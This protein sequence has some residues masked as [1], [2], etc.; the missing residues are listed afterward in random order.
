MMHCRATAATWWSFRGC[1]RRPFV[2]SQ[3]FERHITKTCLDEA[4]AKC[5]SSRNLMMR[6]MTS[7]STLKIDSASTLIGPKSRTSTATR[8]PSHARCG[9]GVLFFAS[10]KAGHHSNWQSP[11]LETRVDLDNSHA[12]S[13]VQVH[14]V[15]A[16]SR[17]RGIG[18]YF[19]KLWRNLVNSPTMA[20]TIQLPSDDR[21]SPGSSF[22]INGLIAN[23]NA[24]L[25]GPEPNFLPY[26]VA[27]GGRN[28]VCN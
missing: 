15:A 10:K 27:Q 9:L 7:P 22:A 4:I 28:G 17:P 12:C 5:S 11:L 20:C 18:G 16:P 3:D 25:A 19:L 13:C 26:R 21:R 8:N 24:C 23:P 2:W 1:R 14:R 6:L